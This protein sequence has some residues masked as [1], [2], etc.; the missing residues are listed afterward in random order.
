MSGHVNA[1]SR[2]GASFLVSPTALLRRDTD[3]HSAA[4]A[5]RDDRKVQRWID[6]VAGLLAR[7]T[8]ATFEDLARVVPQYDEAWQAA[9]RER[10]PA[11]RRTRL[12]SLKRTFE[13]DKDELRHLGVVLQTLPDPEGGQ[14]ASTYRLRATDFYLPYLCV[15]CP[16]RGE[17]AHAVWIDMGTAP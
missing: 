13:R 10:D 8:P 5:P 6:L 17:G 9:Q 4:T 16:V 14:D 7:G 3:Q 12:A 1:G 2:C 11:R 15:A